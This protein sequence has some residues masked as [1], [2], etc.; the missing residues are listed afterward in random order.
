[1]NM[2][3][4]FILFSVFLFLIACEGNSGKSR[5]QIENGT[6]SDTVVSSIKFP[7][8]T[9]KLIV[10]V[11][12]E[13][14]GSMDGYV[15]GVTEFEQAVYNYLSDIKISRITD[16]LNLH[17]INNKIIPQGS[18]ISDFI[19]KLDPSS[20]RARGG[21]RGTS[22]IA[23]VLDSVIKNTKTQNISIL[24]TDGIFSPGRGVDASNYLVNQEI[25]IKR[26]FAEYLAKDNSAAVIVYQLSSNFNG[27]YFNKVDARISINNE[28]RPFYIW[29]IGN[30]KQLS[31]LRTKV[32]D[33]R[34]KGRSGNGIFNIFTAMAGVQPIRYGIKPSSGN[35][36]LSKK[37][38]ETD[39][40][41]LRKDK[42]TGVVRFAVNVDFS[43]LLLDEEYI[44][45]VANYENKSRYE[46]EVKKN[47]GNAGYSH[48]LEFTSDKV[49][50]GP[51]SVKLKANFPDWI[52]MV[53]DDEGDIAVEGKTYGIKYQLGGV[54]D[55]FTFTDKH[56]AEIQVN[57][58]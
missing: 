37:V 25:G 32:A 13:N 52:E 18:D 17:Y 16:T 43:Q 6:D 28:Q 4:Y 38:P 53:N 40:E 11:Y 58:N 5:K 20:F 47:H 29:I 15:H 46:L 35:F 41:K 30:S 19:E 56:Y 39:I 34:I 31:N 23:N 10:N 36:Q 27:I 2:R 33:D 55:A 51:V 7:Y 3:I 48:I 57:I 14:S 1:M 49:S 9:E 45:N 21:N 42:H 8:A 12:V 26:I 22:D 24:I 54:F 50:K 44:L